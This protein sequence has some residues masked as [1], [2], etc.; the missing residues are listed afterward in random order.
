MNIISLICLNILSIIG[1]DALQ[2]DIESH[3]RNSVSKHKR[4][5]SPSSSEKVKVE[6]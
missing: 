6:V 2:R 5:A 1:C 3:P 4:S